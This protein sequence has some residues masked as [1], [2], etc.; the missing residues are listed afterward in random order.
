MG[1]QHVEAWVVTDDYFHWASHGCSCTRQGTLSRWLEPGRERERGSEG[2]RDGDW[3]REWLGENGWRNELT[4]EKKS[5]K[6]LQGALQESWRSSRSK[7]MVA[8]QQS[9]RNR[10]FYFLVLVNPPP[11]KNGC[12][13]VSAQAKIILMITVWCFSWTLE[14]FSRAAKDITTVLQAV[15]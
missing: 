8:E 15:W 6:S 11:K 3:M 10:D 12:F 13:S 9:W 5:Q 7:W 2:A 4:K 1:R 14:S